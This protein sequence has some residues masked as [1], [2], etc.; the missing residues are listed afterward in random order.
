MPSVPTA[1]DIVQNLP[2][3]DRHVWLQ[4][5]M[6][7]VY[8]ND[9]NSGVGFF[10]QLDLL[11]RNPAVN[12]ELLELMHACMSLGFEGKYRHMQGGHEGLMKEKQGTYQAICNVRQMREDGLSPHWKG[13]MIAAKKFS[14]RIPIWVLGAVA[15][16]VLLATFLTLRFLLGFDSDALANQIVQLHPLQQI[17]IE[18]PPFT[19]PPKDP[20]PVKTSQLD[21][22]RA[23]LKENIDNGGM[24]IDP[25][26]DY[27]VI[28]VNN[29]VLFPSGKASVLPEFAPVA[30][31]IAQ[32]LD[33][34]PGPV[35]IIGH[36][37]NVK[38]RSTSRFKNNYELS[39]ARAKSVESIISSVLKDPSRIK[40]EGKG[41]LEPIA[42]NKT[43]EGRAKNRRVEITIPREE[44]LQ[45]PNI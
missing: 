40:V 18:R 44:T 24:T 31:R 27:I 45:E 43:K 33:S 25:V 17:S 9:R 29:M 10:Q 16:G 42:D 38:L 20:P 14:N 15:L 7:A 35:N 4:Y 37:D 32:T 36:T 21:R 6:E 8:F 11:L 22:I 23:G 41:E 26:G 13:L 3:T 39:V 19:P 1:D 34:E 5:S 30:Q 2:G 12:L 28:Q